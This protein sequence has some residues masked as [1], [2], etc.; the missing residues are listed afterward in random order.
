MGTQFLLPYYMAEFSAAIEVL[1]SETS[2]I[3]VHFSD[4]VMLPK[5]C[6]PHKKD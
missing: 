6:E 4:V 5:Q 3:Q 1:D 2:S